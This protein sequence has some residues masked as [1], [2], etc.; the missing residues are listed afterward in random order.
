MILLA[1][2]F[3]TSFGFLFNS[4]FV[5]FILGGKNQNFHCCTSVRFHLFVIGTVAGYE[6]CKYDESE[7][8]I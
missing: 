7:R 8:G 4:I 2:R 3:V 6:G 1:T 5:L